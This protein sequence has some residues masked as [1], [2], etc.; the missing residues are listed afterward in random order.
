[1]P[2]NVTQAQAMIENG[3]HGIIL[4]HRDLSLR[5]ANYFAWKEIEQLV[6]NKKHT[7]VFVLVNRFFFEPELK[8]LAKDLLRLNKLAL[9]GIYFQDYGVAQLIKDAQLSLPLIYHPETLITSYGQ[10]PFYKR[11]GFIRVVL[12][13]ELFK[14]EVAQI[15]RHKPDGLQLEV[16][17]HGFP[18][19]MH[20]RWKMLSN[21]AAYANLELSANKRYWIREKM[22]LYPN[23]VYEDQHGTHMFGGY[24]LCLLHHLKDLAAMGIDCVRI[25]HV[26]QDEQ[27]CKQTTD[28]YL[29]V[30][31]ALNN[32]TLNQQL[33][34]AAFL[35]LKSVCKHPLFASFMGTLDDNPH[36]LRADGKRH[37]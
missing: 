16:Q 24:E 36:L 13:R 26:G 29:K 5:C 32:Q 6:R 19:I 4:G 8:K 31:N 14:S 9:D 17:A 10:L 11:N 22:R 1:M 12:A 2:F 20:S 30:I 25:D 21:F 28:I 33:L 7:K 37:E 3:V 27:W 35:Q 18:F 23:F 15:C 34:D